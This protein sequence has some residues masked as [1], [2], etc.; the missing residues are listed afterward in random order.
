[1]RLAGRY[2]PRS[3]ILAA[4]ET[5][6]LVESYPKDKYVPSYLVL[7]GDSVHILFATDIEGD[8]VRVVT[9]YRPVGAHQEFY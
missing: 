6:E 1:M 9:V 7:A 5:Y 8:N 4:V 2:V 3:E